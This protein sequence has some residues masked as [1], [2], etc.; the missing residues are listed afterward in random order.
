MPVWWFPH[1]VYRQTKL[2]VDK[3]P[4]KTFQ[5]KLL[6]KE[7]MGVK[8]KKKPEQNNF[9]S[10]TISTRDYSIILR[11]FSPLKSS[12]HGLYWTNHEPPLNG[13]DLVSLICI[14]FDMPFLCSKMSVLS[15]SS[16]IGPGVSSWLQ[17]L[18]KKV[19]NDKSLASGVFPVVIL[20]VF[21]LWLNRL[22]V[23]MHLTRTN[24]K[25]KPL[26]VSLITLQI[27]ADCQLFSQESSKISVW[28]I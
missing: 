24:V 9:S 11:L 25:R 23:K 13:F 1:Y 12:T 5:G 17:H 18:S 8:E 22:Q 27:I 16:W 10:E 2:T 7:L 21:F 14:S 28:K 19:N 20:H 26:T 4:V 6:K 15:K 3:N